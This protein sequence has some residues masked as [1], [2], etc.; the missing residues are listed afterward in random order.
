MKL[1]YRGANYDYNP[2]M[3]EVT[4]SEIAC[5]YRAQPTRYTYVRH[6]PIPQSAEKLT[7]RGASYRTSKTGEVL[8]VDG[9]PLSNSGSIAAKLSILRDKLMGTSSAAQAR[10]QLLQESSKLHRESI[11]RS[12]QRR[13]DVARAQGNEQLIQQLEREMSQVG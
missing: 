8:S 6:V 1:T 7:Y 5:C 3:L 11:A 13:I 2:P 9:T 12:L 10:R 4:E